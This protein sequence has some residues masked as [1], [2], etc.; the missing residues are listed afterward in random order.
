MSEPDFPTL[1][2]EQQAEERNAS[3]AMLR[4][5]QAK[6]DSLSLLEKQTLY[7]QL[8]DTVDGALL[9]FEES[10]RRILDQMGAPLHGGCVSDYR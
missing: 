10:S 5:L 6:L 7:K 2:K 3:E 4:F 1:S 9:G 8:T